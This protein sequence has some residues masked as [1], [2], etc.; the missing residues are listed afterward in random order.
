M[1]KVGEHHHGSLGSSNEVS[2][3]VEEL[4]FTLGEGPCVDA[5]DTGRPVSEPDLADPTA[6]RW[7]AFSAPALDAGVRAVFAFPFTARSDPARRTRS[8]L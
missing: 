4:Q 2:D 3:L 1:F 5:Y 7:A 6:L 8:A